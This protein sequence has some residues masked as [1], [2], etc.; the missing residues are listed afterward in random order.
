MGDFFLCGFLS[1]ENWSCLRQTWQE[2][3]SPDLDHGSIILTRWT[4]GGHVGQ[5]EW[6]RAVSRATRATPLCPSLHL[7]GTFP[8]NTVTCLFVV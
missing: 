3:E 2:T 7:H 4:R 1:K 6:R 8:D 5:R